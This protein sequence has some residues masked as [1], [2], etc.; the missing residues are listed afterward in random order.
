M[1]SFTKLEEQGRFEKQLS[2]PHHPIPKPKPS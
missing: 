2:T 1:N